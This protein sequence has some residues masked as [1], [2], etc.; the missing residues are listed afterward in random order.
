MFIKGLFRAAPQGH[1]VAAYSGSG[2]A[3]TYFA[4]VGKVGKAPPGPCPS[5]LRLHLVPPRSARPL[6]P[7]P[8]YGGFMN[9]GV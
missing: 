2:T 1:F 7:D 6:V 5:R 4:R 9:F 8:V 3:A